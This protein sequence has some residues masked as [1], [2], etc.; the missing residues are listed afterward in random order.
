SREARKLAGADSSDVGLQQLLWLAQGDVKLPEARKTDALLEQRLMEVLGVLVTNRDARFKEKLDKNCEKWYTAQ[1]GAAAKHSPVTQLT[2]LRDERKAAFDAGEREY[3]EVEAVVAA[4]QQAE[5]QI[6]DLERH[7]RDAEAEVEALRAERTRTTAR[8]QQFAEAERGAGAATQA[9]DAAAKRLEQ[10]RGRRSRWQEAERKSAELEIR[11]EQRAEELSRRRQQLV[12]ATEALDA[13]RQA[14]DALQDERTELETRRRLA[15]LAVEEAAADEALRKAVEAQAAA[16]AS[17]QRAAGLHAPDEKAL[18]DLHAKRGDRERLRAQLDAA[19]LVLRL[20]RDADPHAPPF[21]LGVD[22]DPPAPADLAPGATLEQAI[23]R[24]FHLI[25]HGVG[26]IELC[27]GR[28]DRDLDR[29]ARDLDRLDKELALALRSFGEEPDDPAAWNRLTERRFALLEAQRRLEADRKT[30]KAALPA[31]GLPAL[32][33]KRRTLGQERDALLAE[34][35]AL[36]ATPGDTSAAD[37]AARD[38]DWK[39]RGAQAA[40][41]RKLAETT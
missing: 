1:R 32:E 4:Q 37:L 30:L 17:E 40:A 28:D 7:T 29:V 41:A 15:A 5:D 6:P 26:V 24:G 19:A 3:R 11:R 12:A 14:V 35:P 38:A 8:R 13:A 18:A 20:T 16:T 21:D 34:H 39:R 36:A 23:R 27:R 10:W 9:R 25:I 22:D 2:K 31:G 33:A